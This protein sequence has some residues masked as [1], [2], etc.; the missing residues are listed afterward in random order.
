MAKELK[1][2]YIER[3][4]KPSINKNENIFKFYF[5]NNETEVCGPYWNDT[6]CIGIVEPPYNK[7]INSIGIVTTTKLDLFLLTE[8]EYYFN[9]LDGADK[10]VSLGYDVLENSPYDR[11]VFQFGDTIDIVREK[12]DRA[13]VSINISDNCIDEENDEF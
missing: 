3:L 9:Y 11:I 1:L 4:F 8:I 13:S 5:T 2:C 7:Y 6:P 12:L 10:I